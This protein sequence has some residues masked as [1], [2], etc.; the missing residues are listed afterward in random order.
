MTGGDRHR[1]QPLVGVCAYTWAMHRGPAGPA[2]CSARGT[3]VLSTAPT[4]SW[5]SLRRTAGRTPKHFWPVWRSFP[6]ANV[7]YQ[8]TTFEEIDLAAVLA[9]RPTAALVD[10]LAHC[11]VPGA[12]HAR[13]WQD[14]G[15]LLAAGIDVIST[16]SV[17]Q[18]ESLSDVVEKITGV[19]HRETVPD[20][21]VRAAGE[22]ELVD[23]APQALQERLAQEY[24]YPPERAGAAL[25]S[26]FQ[27]PNLSALREL[28]LLWLAG[29][30]ASER[31]RS[32]PGGQAPGD[33]HARERVVVALSGGPEGETLIR[34]AARIAT[35]SAGDLL[36][37][38]AARPAGPAT[39]G[40]AAL[41]AQRQLTVSLGGTYHQLADPDIPA[42]LL[43]F[44]QAE[45]ATQLVLGVARRTRLA[46][47]PL[48]TTIRSQLIRRGGGIS[49]HVVR[50]PPTANSV[51]PAERDPDKSRRTAMQR[52]ISWPSRLRLA[53][54][55]SRGGQPPGRKAS[56]CGPRDRRWP[57]TLRCADSARHGLQIP[58][59][60]NAWCGAHWNSV[61]VAF[62]VV[63]VDD[64]PRFS[65][66]L[67]I[68][69]NARGCAS[70]AWPRP[71]R[72]RCSEQRSS[73]RISSWSTSAWAT[74]TGSTLPGAWSNTNAAAGPR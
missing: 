44:T 29:K 36:A 33:G 70:S 25:G 60:S 69:W 71:Q 27:T 4:L 48:T 49:V 26:W 7:P 3:G 56:L 8:G 31:R 10:D 61:R 1:D 20:P 21:V 51:P 12:G 24:I 2:R 45:N 14:A 73:A 62:G 66:L 63:I 46:A 22:V 74:R 30:L 18:L 53:G 13:R 58:A 43:A 34:R 42:A 72:R 17:G 5:L 19:P 6:P 38:H 32:R 50:C 47:P 55:W 67:G 64:N 52:K 68:S 65:R 35:W 11:N 39:A 28:A 16:V 9:R 37:V 23:V 41:A 40:R 57:A 59:S 54:R 15:D